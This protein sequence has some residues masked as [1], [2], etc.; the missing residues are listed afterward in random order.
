MIIRIFGPPGTGKTYTL[1]RI[2]YHLIG[3]EDN[4]EFLS[5]Y[6]LD[7]PHKAYTLPQIAYISFMNSA[8][9]ELLNRIGV[10][11]D[12][13]RGPWGTLHGLTLHLLLKDGVIPKEIVTNSFG[14]RTG[15]YY[16]RKKF[17][18]EYGIPYDPNEEARTLPG[19]QLFDGLSYV[20]NVYYPKYQDMGRVLDKFSRSFPEL[21]PY[22]IEWL[23]FK[24]VNNIID[25]DD[26]LIIAFHNDSLSLDAKVLI[27]DEFQDFGPLQYEIFKRLADGKDYVFVAGDDDQVVTQY[28]G[29]DPKFLIEM[30]DVGADY[31]VVLKQSFR[32]PKV[33]HEASQKF[34]KMYVKYRYPK[35]F[36][37]RDEE[38]ELFLAKMSIYHLPKVAYKLAEKG[39]DVLIMAR[40]NNMV[41]E[42]ESVF[43]EYGIEYFRFKTRSVQVWSNFINRIYNVVSAVRLGKRPQPSDLKFFFRFVRGASKDIDTILNSKS[44]PLTSLKVFNNPVPY[45]N[46]AKVADYLGSYEK[47]QLAL[48]A[49]D[50]LISGKLKRPKG[51]IYIDTV[52]ASKGREADV[53]FLLDGITS[54]IYEEIARSRDDFEAEM[55]VWYVGMTRA[56]H[57]LFLVSLDLPIVYP[58]LSKAGVEVKK[59]GG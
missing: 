18:T 27:V 45:I 33:V 42:I 40:T 43:L 31:S 28:N 53:V 36:L 30:P 15:V 23:K 39:Y 17:T 38:G 1:N 5:L 46:I 44:I 55:R 12:Y 3:V 52:H 9:D 49:L 8:V 58:L 50:G 13:R 19:N 25:F 57:M 37:P 34:I 41:R 35:E 10:T 22:A 4:T 29:S 54:R 56:R 48:R 59:V 26:I 6:G 2:V 7:L 11:R 14:T 24:R 47:A 20:I 51:N 21:Y 32:I 16:W